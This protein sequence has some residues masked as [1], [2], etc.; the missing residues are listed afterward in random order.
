M[1]SAAKLRVEFDR[2]TDGRWIAEVI[3]GHYLQTFCIELD[4]NWSQLAI[5][6]GALR[7]ALKT[8]GGTR[9]RSSES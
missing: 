7:S 5:G 1:T 8:T 6:S 3:A 4:L 2:E 9:K